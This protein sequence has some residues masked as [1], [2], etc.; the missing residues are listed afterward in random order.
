MPFVA[1]IPAWFAVVSPEMAPTYGS[2]RASIVGEATG[3][4]GALALAQATMLAPDDESMGP[5]NDAWANPSALAPGEVDAVE[6]PWQ[7]WKAL[8]DLASPPEG[9]TRPGPWI[10]EREVKLQPVEGGWAL[11]VRWTVVAQRPGWLWDTLAGSTIE[12]RSTT[13]EGSPAPVVPLPGGARLGLWVERG[14]ELRLR[15]FIRGSLDDRIELELMSA[16]RGRLHIDAPGRVP[17]PVVDPDAGYS[18]PVLDGGIVWSGAS[19]VALDLRDPSQAPPTRE[20]LAVAHAGVGL[21]IGDAELRGHAHLQWEL[22]HGSLPRVRASVAGLGDDLVIT[23]RDITTWSR[24]G[25]V[26]EVQLGAPATGRVDLDLRWTQAIPAGDEASIIL[27][28]I[29]PEAWRSEASLQVAR[30]GEHEVIPRPEGWTAVAASALPQWGQGLVEGT[31]TAA[32][33]RSGGHRDGALDLMRFVP[34]PGPPTVVDVA[35]YTMATT[36][37]GRVLM[38]ARYELRND[39]GAHLTVRPPEG[40]RIIGARVAGQTALPSRGDDGAWR[41]PLKRSLETVEGLLSFAVEVTLIGE[42]QAWAR[43]ERRD[44]VLPT[45]DAPIAAARA[46]VHLP[47]GYRNRIEASEHNVVE[48]FDDSDGLTY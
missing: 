14:G 11:D 13:F 28:R 44:I 42:D 8:H 23:G 48:S 25:D 18:P 1:L 32:Y 19:I 7:T 22:R 33:Q 15:A 12:I 41:L 26:L 29:E 43:R 39:R 24:N 37:E 46:T 34:V 35:T 27:P 16:T 21:T 38:R 47:P 45:L 9:K 6:V 30:D 36:E 40:M 5:R 3:G 10:S 2:A 20:T 31:P 17:V 4:G